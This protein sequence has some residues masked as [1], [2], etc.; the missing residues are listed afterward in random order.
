M[1]VRNL[2]LL[3]DTLYTL[4][5]L[6]ELL[7]RTKEEVV[8]GV[9]RGFAAE[10]VKAQFGS[11]ARIVDTGELASVDVDLSS[12][13][14]YKIAT[15]GLFEP[16]QRRYHISEAFARMLEAD[17]DWGGDFRPLTGWAHGSRTEPGNRCVIAPFS[18]SCASHRGFRANKTLAHERWSLVIGWLRRV[19]FAPLVL[20]APDEQWGGAEV[21]TVEAA[22]LADLVDILSQARLVITVDNGI[23]HVA[24]ALGCRTVIVWPPVSDLN[25]IGPVWNPRTALI[26]CR[27]ERLRADQLLTLIRK[28]IDT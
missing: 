18:R 23:G 26:P 21:E 3:G 12:W 22:S 9:G 1:R 16:R 13:T 11:L 14:A 5:P 10:M 2:N 25:F 17:V 7:M 15:N 4:K 27:P 6:A 20:Q 28:E 8:I 19:G 24:S